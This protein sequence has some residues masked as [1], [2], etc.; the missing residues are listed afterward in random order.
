MWPGSVVVVT[1]DGLNEFPPRESSFF[2]VGV[3]VLDDWGETS[4]LTSFFPDWP[5]AVKTPMAVIAIP[6]TL[7]PT[8]RKTRCVL[9]CPSRLR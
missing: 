8:L 1:G 3:A 5:H 9:M 6:A 2:S 4:V 7:A